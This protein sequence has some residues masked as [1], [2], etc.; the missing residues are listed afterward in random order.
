M[1]VALC[2]PY[3][4]VICTLLSVIIDINIHNYLSVLTLV[5]KSSEVCLKVSIFQH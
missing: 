5:Y 4:S 2:L 3:V 1:P